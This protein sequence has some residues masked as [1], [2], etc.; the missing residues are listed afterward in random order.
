M[1]LVSTIQ[2]GESAIHIQISPILGFLS[3]VGHHRALNRVPCAIQ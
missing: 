3:N 1:L 2:Q